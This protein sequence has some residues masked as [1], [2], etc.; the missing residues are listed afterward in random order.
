ML[1]KYVYILLIHGMSSASLGNP[2][3]HRLFGD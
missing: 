2:D 1:G 3:R